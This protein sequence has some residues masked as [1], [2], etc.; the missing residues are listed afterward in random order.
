MV[1]AF[2]VTS[3]LILLPFPLSLQ[4]P[5]V[6]RVHFERDSEY[7]TLETMIHLSEMWTSCTRINP[8]EAL[9]P[10]AIYILLESY[11]EIERGFGFATWMRSRIK[12]FT[13]QYLVAQNRL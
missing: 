1:V 10:R 6:Q 13:L 4:P 5:R 9:T 12:L 8:S 11:I 2:A 3:F 7:A